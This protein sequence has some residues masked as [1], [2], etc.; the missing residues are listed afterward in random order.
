MIIIGYGKEGDV[1]DERDKRDEL[2]L[3]ATSAATSCREAHEDNNRANDN[4]ERHGA[5]AGSNQPKWRV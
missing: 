4:S 3:S 2:V 1:Q 5:G